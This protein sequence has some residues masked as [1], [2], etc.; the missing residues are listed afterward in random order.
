MDILDPDYINMKPIGGGQEPPEKPPPPEQI[1]T[2]E[3]A[4]VFDQNQDS[5]E[6]WV[7][8]AYRPFADVRPINFSGGGQQQ[9][10]GLEPGVDAAVQMISFTVADETN[11]TLY[12]G[13]NAKSG[14]MDFGGAGEPRGI[15]MSFPYP[16]FK[17]RGDFSI[18]S[19]EA[20]QV[21]GMV[22]FILF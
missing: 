17:V 3:Y 2:A 21:S 19:S 9:L 11:I 8:S 20:V 16:G 10:I 5:Y 6:D 12:F 18:G 14:P 1:Y 7:L 13:G 4:S 22:S 15:V